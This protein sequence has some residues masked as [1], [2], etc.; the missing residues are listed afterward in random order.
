LADGQ[1]ATRFVIDLSRF[2]GVVVGKPSSLSLVDGEKNARVP[3]I[4]VG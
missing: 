3:G 4:A 1:A 2:S